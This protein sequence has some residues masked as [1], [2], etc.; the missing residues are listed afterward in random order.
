MLSRTRVNFDIPKPPKIAFPNFSVAIRI[1][2]SFHDCLFGRAQSGFPSPAESFCVAQEPFSFFYMSCSSFDSCHINKLK[3]TI[4]M[5][6]SKKLL[7]VWFWYGHPAPL[8]P[9]CFACLFGKIVVLTRNTPEDFSVFCKFEPFCYRF[10]YVS[11]F[12]HGYMIAQLTNAV[13]VL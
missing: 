3:R 9:S 6:V 1:D 7:S 4:K 2:P 5:K 12:C 11:V 13:N 8:G 10:S